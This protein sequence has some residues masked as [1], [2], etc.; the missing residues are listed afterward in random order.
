MHPLSNHKELSK[1]ARQERQP[2]IPANEV[3]KDQKK[4]IGGAANLERLSVKVR[5][6]MSH[7]S[8]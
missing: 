7:T 8:V 3:K 5:C 4:L 2:S 1:P 6:N